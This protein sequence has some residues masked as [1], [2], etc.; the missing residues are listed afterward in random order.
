MH[1][2]SYK[3]RSVIQMIFVLFFNQKRNFIRSI[4]SNYGSIENFD[5]DIRTHSHYFSLIHNCLTISKLFNSAIAISTARVPLAS[6]SPAFFSDHDISFDWGSNRLYLSVAL[7]SAL[8]AHY[9][10]ALNV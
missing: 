2:I 7:W 4:L 9:Y 6:F 5:P 1:A 3:K 10:I 8:I